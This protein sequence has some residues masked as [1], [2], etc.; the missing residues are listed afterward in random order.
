MEG[1]I[2][3]IAI[4]ELAPDRY[5]T[6]HAQR[7]QDEVLEVGP[8]IFAIAI[9]HLQGEV[10]GL[11]KLV[12]AP[13][14]V[15]GRIKVDIAARQTAWPPGRHRPCRAAWCRSRRGDR[16]PGPRYRR[17]RPAEALSCLRAGRCLAERRTLLSGTADCGH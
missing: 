11:G 5:R 1:L 6:I 9:G 13:D 14:T 12:I 3:G 2:G 10:L 17:S 16:G 15:G 8:C 7:G 4:V